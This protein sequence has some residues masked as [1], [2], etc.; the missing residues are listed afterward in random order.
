M[1]DFSG[2]Q[3]IS[4]NKVR[5]GQ[6]W[7]RASDLSFGFNT[8]YWKTKSIKRNASIN[9]RKLKKQIWIGQWSW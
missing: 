3:I 1:V 7:D 4:Y 5:L 8:L 9:Q 6:R 2:L